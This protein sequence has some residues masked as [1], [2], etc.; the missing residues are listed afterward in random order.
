MRIAKILSAV[1]L[2]ASAMVAQ[3]PAPSAAP[4][5]PVSFDKAAM[6]LTAN[7]CQDFYQ[8]TC[9]GWRANNP[10]PPDQS[11]WGRF[12]E[13]SEYN[14]NVLHNILED[15]SKKKNATPLEQKVGDFYAACMD[16]SRV[17]SLGT[18][19][20]DAELSRISKLKDRK[21]L[22]AE[23]AHLY[24]TGRGGSA[25][26]FYINPDLHNASMNIALVDQGGLTLPDR[27][28]YLKD[29]AKMVETRQ[30]Y[31][32]YVTNMFKLVGETQA[33]A[34][35]DA[36]TVLALETEIAKGHMDR[37]ARR[38][39][40]NR[41]HK[42]TVVQ[43][44]E[45][46]PNVDFNQ[47][48]VAAGVGKFDDLNV[49]NPNFFKNLNGLIASQPIDAWKAYLRWRVLSSQAN[50][51]SKPFVEESF[52]FNGK[53]MSGAKELPPR[54][55]RCTRMTD[56][57]LGE[58]LGPLYVE[59]AFPPDAKAR[60]LKLV[61]AIEKA[62]DAD[63]KEIDWMS[64][65]TKKQAYGKLQATQNKIGYPD[66]WKDYS[67]VTIKRDDLVGNY[68]A[69]Q[70]FE[71]KRNLNKLGKP[72]DKLEWGM[73]PPTVNAYYNPS[74]NNI[75]FPAGIL[76]PPFFS[77]S[78]DDA[79]NFGGIGVVIGHELTHGFDDSGRRFA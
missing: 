4:K 64:P 11:R 50:L 69:A 5:A 77:N 52:D 51:L 18:K 78:I 55:K 16:E 8:Y 47:Y 24:V 41:D 79:V 15:V 3:T 54:W 7:P 45:L 70:V 57:S 19:P 58:A 56:S 6:D 37:V 30:K 38:D 62:M 27:D 43:L 32:E 31:T 75:N 35:A 40:R 26:A 23:L 74:Q 46:A 21:E 44:A 61:D 28:Y 12:N 53:Y 49:T 13:L 25:F 68:A 65:E 48:F 39:A 34:E 14:L 9:G 59:K 71:I 63:I 1:V 42:M 36:K 66:K 22:I 76:Q 20:I 72:V 60:M 17:E 2:I 67:S 29:D 33:Q 73:T 10:I